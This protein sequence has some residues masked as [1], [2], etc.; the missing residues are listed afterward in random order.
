MTAMAPLDAQDANAEL[1]QALDWFEKPP[2]GPF[3]APAIEGAF[4]RFAAAAM[5]ASQMRLVEEVLT[6]AIE[7]IVMAAAKHGKEGE[8]GTLVKWFWHYRREPVTP[9]QSILGG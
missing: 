1:V 6:Q 3:W 7:Q 8:F 5:T 2:A 9:A 4:D